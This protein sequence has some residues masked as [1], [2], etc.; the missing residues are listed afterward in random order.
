[1]NDEE[2]MLQ[3]CNGNKQAFGALVKKYIDNAKIRAEFLLGDEGCDAVQEA[4]IKTWRNAYKWNPKKASFATWFNTV[5][6]NTC[7]DFL[8]KRKNFYVK[9]NIDDNFLKNIEASIKSPEERVICKNKNA[10]VQKALNSLSK[11]HK[12]II[13]LIYYKQYSNREAAELIGRKLKAAESL[14][15]RA[16]HKLKQEIEKLNK[17]ENGYEK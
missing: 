14:L 17:K 2:L 9:E 11:K 15:I 7:Y 3:V 5:L 8:K 12:E 13:W 10:Q 1:M 16:R 4:F 6:N